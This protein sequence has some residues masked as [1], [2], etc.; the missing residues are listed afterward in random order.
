MDLLRGAPDQLAGASLTIDAVALRTRRLPAT[1]SPLEYLAHTR[2]VLAWYAQRIE[3]VRSE[4]PPHLDG[5]DWTA[6]TEAACYHDEDLAAV[7]AGVEREAVS[8]A[9]A[10]G[11]LRD[12]EW[13]RV[14]IGSEGDERSI[15]QLA[16]RA[17]HELEHHLMDVEVRS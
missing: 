17:V 12:N 8:L 10:L 6:A 7:L 9:D 14:G 16:R 5:L 1:W 15:L 11:S 3:R 4:T 13:I 2:D